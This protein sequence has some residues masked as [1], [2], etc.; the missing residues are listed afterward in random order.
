[1]KRIF[2]ALMVT[3]CFVS[4]E[5]FVEIDAPKTQIVTK[6]LFANDVGAKSAMAGVYSQL[7]NNSTFASGGVDG[8][9]AIAGLAADELDNHSTNQRQVALYNNSLTPIN[10]VSSM[11]NGLY[12]TIY[13]VNSLLEGVESSESITKPV[14]DQITGEA[15]FLRAF[16]YFYL[17]GFYG[18]VPL[19][20]TTDYRVNREASRTSVDEVYQ[21]I[22]ADLLKSQMLLLADYSFSNNEKVNPNKWAASSLLA[23][24]Y[25]Y[26]GK[27]ENAEV[28]SASVIES[29]LFSLADLNSVFLANSTEAIFQLQSVL[30]GFNTLD[31]LFYYQQSSLVSASTSDHVLNA[32]EPNDNRAI[33]WIGN[34]DDGSLS[35]SY[36]NKYRVHSRDQPLTE[37]Q[38][39][40]RL[41]EQLLIRAEAR[42]MQSDLEGAIN[43][44]NEIRIRAGLDQIDAD[45]LS[46]EQVL[47]AIEQERRAE[48][49]IEWGHR[50]F[51][52]KRTG[53]IDEVLGSVKPDWQS[54][55][56]L[57]PISQLEINANP[58]LKQNP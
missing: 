48:L 24:V 29:G 11:W 47:S 23:R 44:V 21:Q 3:V 14:R 57:F 49:F 55:D 12:Q 50:W 39:V 13:N 27:W 10:T 2:T 26:Q 41:A 18:D 33:A 40:L 37:Y 51:D 6:N 20:L 46:Q 7:M 42:A 8:I 31:G 34:Y 56:S 25:L 35:Y 43:D 45:G 17:I 58:N 9:T 30:P 1:M 15:L 54:K 32:F 4:C 22:E 19:L 38:M 28:Q 16:C 53:K 52:L 5:N 36:V